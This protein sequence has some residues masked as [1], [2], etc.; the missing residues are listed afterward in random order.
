LPAFQLLLIHT[1]IHSTTKQSAVGVDTAGALMY[2]CVSSA[3]DCA[4][5]LPLAITS[6]S[7]ALFPVLVEVK[8][9]F[10]EPGCRCAHSPSSSKTPGISYQSTMKT[11]VRMLKTSGGV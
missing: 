4:V 10:V 7:L 9:S 1:S 2:T 8:L 11:S 3:Y 5:K 6:N